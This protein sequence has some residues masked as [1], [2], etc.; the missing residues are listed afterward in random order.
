MSA[1]AQTDECRGVDGVEQ[2]PHLLGRQHGRLALLHAML[3]P[4]HRVRRVDRDD[5]AS[6]EP[7]EEHPDGGEVLLDAG[8][9]HR[10]AEV[11][12]VGGNVNRL[13][14]FERELPAFA[15]S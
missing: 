4:A 8:L 7:V 12:D 15:P 2:N 10:F 11:L 9:R 1:I 3:W 6:D 5:L 14:L 13:G